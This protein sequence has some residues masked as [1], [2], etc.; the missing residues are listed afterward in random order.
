M[1]ESGIKMTLWG[2]VSL[3]RISGNSLLRNCWMASVPF[4]VV[5][6]L[7]RLY[8]MD[9]FCQGKKSCS[10]KDKIM[11][12]NYSLQKILN[13]NLNQKVLKKVRTN[14]TSNFRQ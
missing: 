13:T 6:S 5:W 8:S 2:L 1:N 10:V 9:A 12:Y 14:V 4:L 3:S 11:Y 7:P